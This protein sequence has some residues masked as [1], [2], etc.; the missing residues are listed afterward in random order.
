MSK[1]LFEKWCEI[2]GDKSGMQHAKKLWPK[3]VGGRWNS[4]TEVEQRMLDIGGMSMMLPVLLEVLKKKDKDK[5]NKKDLP[6]MMMLLMKFLLM[7]QS[8]TNVIWGLGG[9]RH[10]NVLKTPLWWV[11]SETMR[12]AQSLGLTCPFLGARAVTVTVTVTTAISG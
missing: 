2:H 8:S 12:L 11:L 1:A 6:P 9:K 3:A 5:D 10:W 4:I 7:R